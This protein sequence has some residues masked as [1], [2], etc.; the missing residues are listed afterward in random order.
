MLLLAALLAS[1]QGT[2]FGSLRVVGSGFF[3]LVIVSR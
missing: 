1:R 3:F 2:D